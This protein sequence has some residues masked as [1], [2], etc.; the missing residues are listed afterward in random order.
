MKIIWD[1]LDIAERLKEIDPEYELHYDRNTGKFTLRDS[2]GNV[3]LTYRYPT[4]DVRM[5]ADARRTRIE[6]MTAVLREIESANERAEESYHRAEENNIKDGLQDAA[7]RY[8]SG[9]RRGR[10]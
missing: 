7:E 5:I 1:A 8:Y 4:I 6:R 2:R 3:Q 9:L 10:Y